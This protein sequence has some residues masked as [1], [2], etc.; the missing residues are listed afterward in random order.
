[1]PLAWQNSCTDCALVISDPPSL[2]IDGDMEPQMFDFEKRNHPEKIIAHRADYIG[3]YSAMIGRN[4]F[5]L[6]SF[7][8]S[9]MH[10]RCFYRYI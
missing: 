8:H 6:T 9:R 7:E 5:A 3:V 10:Y 1:M 2:V 4:D